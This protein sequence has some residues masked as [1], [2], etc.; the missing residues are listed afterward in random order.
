MRILLQ[1]VICAMSLTVSGVK[2]DH[3]F[4]TYSIAVW[5]ATLLLVRG[6]LGVGTLDIHGEVNIH[7]R[8]RRDIR[9]I[10]EITQV[11]RRWDIAQ[12]RLD[13]EDEQ[14]C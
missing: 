10:A 8:R 11:T 3:D 7:H 1:A 13:S 4:P 9:C 2:P 5:P 12:C 14:Q 6:I